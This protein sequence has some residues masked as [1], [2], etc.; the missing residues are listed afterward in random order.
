MDLI[1]C[2]NETRIDVYL[3]VHYNYIVYR[4]GVIFS[5]VSTPSKP[6]HQ[7]AWFLQSMKWMAFFFQVL[8]FEK[9]SSGARS[10]PCAYTKDSN[11]TMHYIKS[12]AERCVYHKLSFHKYHRKYFDLPIRD[13]NNTQKNITFSINTLFFCEYNKID[14]DIRWN[15]FWTKLLDSEF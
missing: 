5:L 13:I 3:P 12:I 7:H 2:V 8:K 10:L 9:K 1:L 11:K 6:Y 4:N 15:S 14:L